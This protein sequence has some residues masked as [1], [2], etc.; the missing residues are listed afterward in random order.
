MDGLCGPMSYNKRALGGYAMEMGPSESILLRNKLWID[1]DDNRTYLIWGS[2]SPLL[3]ADENQQTIDDSIKVLRRNLAH[4]LIRKHPSWWMDLFGAC[5]YNCEKLWQQVKLFKKAEIDIM[6]NPLPFT[7]EVGVVYDDASM[8]AIGSHSYATSCRLLYLFCPDLSASGVPYGQYLLGDILDGKTAPKLTF[9]NAIFALDG[10]QRKILR[11]FVKKSVCVWGWAPGYIDLD[12][13]KFSADAVRE[14]SGF[15]VVPAGDVY[16]QAA[17]TE[18]GKKAGIVPFGQTTVKLSILFSP[19]PEKGDVVLAKYTNG[20][21]CVVYRPARGGNRPE[22]FCGTPRVPYEL[23]KFAEKIADVHVYADNRASVIANGAYLSVSATE[24]GLVT[25]DVK[26]DKPV[27]DIA[28]KKKIGNGPI[29]KL[30]MKKGDTKFLRIGKG[31]SDLQKA[32]K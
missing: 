16:P 4:Q 27:L 6:K 3:G 22:I 29:L 11:D 25:L 2:G 18:E 17:P 20:L 13:G 21:P 14:T 24:D 19:V 30:E 1:E 26:S 32:D 7:P 31:N 23:I 28:T 12:A 8:C 9:M 15:S 10:K 5:W